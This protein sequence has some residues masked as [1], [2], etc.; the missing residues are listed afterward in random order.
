[1]PELTALSLL[2]TDTVEIRDVWCEGRHAHRSGEECT[3]ATY[4][5]FPYR[6]VFVRH[7]GR[8][9]AVAEANQVLLFNSCETYRVSHPVPGGDA[10]VSLLVKH[11]VLDEL[12]AGAGFRRCLAAFRR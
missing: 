9:E 10:S 11:P 4:L 1:M 7:V 12:A 5:V 2:E 8:D 3:I 6:G